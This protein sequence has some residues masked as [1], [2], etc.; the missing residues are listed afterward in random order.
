MSFEENNGF[1]PQ[2]LMPELNR[3]PQNLSRIHLMGVCGTG[4]ASLAGMLKTEGYEVSG[5][6]ANVYPPMSLLLES[7]KI[8][9]F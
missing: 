8:P 9:R 2:A 7:L 5:S 3:R 4:M 1:I 6:D